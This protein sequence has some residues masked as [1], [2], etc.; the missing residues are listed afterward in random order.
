MSRLD[1]GRLTLRIDWCDLHDLINKVV[2]TLS[3]ELTPFK[4]DVVLPDDLSL[5]KLDFGLMEQVIH[6][7]LLNA[8]QLSHEGSSIRV[9][10]FY[11]NGFLFIQVMDRGPGFSNSEL[12]HL[13]DKFYRGD[14]AAAGGTGLGLSIVKGIVEAHRGTITAE[15]RTNGGALFTIKIPTECSNLT[16]LQNENKLL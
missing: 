16:D 12:P 5:V 11:D 13:F 15:N 9:K 6:N 3:A 10:F 7:L 4:I 8:T 1:S 14:S 2:Q